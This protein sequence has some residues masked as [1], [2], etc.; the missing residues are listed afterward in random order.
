MGHRRTVTGRQTKRARKSKN[1][2]GEQRERPIVF[3]MKNL[4]QG[5]REGEG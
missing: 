3:S 4:K 5:L 1:G 2:G